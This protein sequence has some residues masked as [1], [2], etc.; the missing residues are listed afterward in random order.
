MK[1]NKEEEK[2]FVDAKNKVKR[3][4]NFYLHLALYSIVVAL[5]LYNLYII[6]GPYTDVITGLNISIMVLWTVI[7]SIHAWSVF[8]GRL[9]FKKS[10]EDKKIEKIL[11]EKEKENVETTFWE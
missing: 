5:L 10:W 4:K 11:K 3:I 8:R 7:I 6:Q 9:L 1:L 2:R